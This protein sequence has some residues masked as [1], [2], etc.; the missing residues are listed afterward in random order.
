MGSGEGITEG[1][2]LENL[3]Q[4]RDSRKFTKFLVGCPREQDEGPEE[5]KWS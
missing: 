5:S 2:Q 1:A 3:A 4:N